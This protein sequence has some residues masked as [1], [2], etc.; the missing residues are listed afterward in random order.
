MV[1]NAHH[2]KAV[3]GRKTDVKDAGWIADLLRHGLV[4]ASF[5]P[6]REQRELG[7]YRRGLIRERSRVVN[8]IQK[9]LEG[10]NIKLSSVASD[11]VGAS[12]RAMLEALHGL[13]NPH[14]RAM[15]Q[16]QLRHLGFLDQEISSMDREV[17]ERMGP[18]EEAGKRIERLGY[19]VILEPPPNPKPY[20][21][22][23]DSLVNT[24]SLCCS[25][26]R[27]TRRWVS[28]KAMALISASKG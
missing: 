5:I 1:V 12:G 8:R 22:S 26:R 21:P 27:F 13:M 28:M 15:L 17:E 4:R 23:N 2:I 7:R 14:Q 24:W 20:S 10:A 3:P 19:N 18:L 6:D 9:V 25:K 16:S 11:V